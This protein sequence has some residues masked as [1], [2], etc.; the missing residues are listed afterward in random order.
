MP[1]RKK[2]LKKQMKGLL[3]Q[4]EKHKIKAETQKG[5]NDT[6][7]EY[8]IGEAD[9]FEEREKQRAEMLKKLKKK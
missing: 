7:K 2:R 6:T 4:A 5:R 3:K 9:R 1:N 8:W